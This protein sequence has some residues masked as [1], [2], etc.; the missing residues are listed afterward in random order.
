MKRIRIFLTSI[1]KEIR[2]FLTRVTSFLKGIRIYL[3]PI[4]LLLAA[5]LLRLDSTHDLSWWFDFFQ[6]SKWWLA[7]FILGVA[8]IPITGVIFKF[9]DTKGYIFSKVIGLAVSGYIVWMLG[10]LRI[11]PFTAWVC[12]LVIA[13]CLGINCFV[14]HK[15]KIFRRFIKDKSFLRKIVFQ[16]A[17]FMFALFFWTYLRGMRPEIIGI[18]KFMNF[19]F[20]NSILRSEYFPPPDMWFAGEHIN[21]YYLGHYFSAFLTR[22]SFVPPEISYN[23]MIATL[24]ALSFMGA[25]SIGEFLFE[26]FLQNAKDFQPFKYT[27]PICGLLTGALVALSGNMHTPYYTLFDR[28][29]YGFDYFPP[30]AT[31]YIGSHPYIHGDH[32]IHEFPVYS[33]VLA[34][35][36]AH[37]TN[38]IFVLTAIAV[39]IAVTMSMLEKDKFKKNKYKNNKFKKGG[40]KNESAI[41]II[42]GICLIAL[43][44][45]LFPVAG[46]WQLPNQLIAAIVFA[47]VGV[48]L[49]ITLVGFPQGFKRYWP[50]YCLVVFLIGLFPTTNYWDF[51]IYIVV[52]GV[53]YFYACLRISGYK[54]KALILLIY[55]VLVIGIGAFLV[56]TLFHLNF[57]TISTQVLPV[58]R[59]SAL[60]QLLILY[61][62]QVVFFAMLVVTSILAYNRLKGAQDV[63]HNSSLDMPL[64]LSSVDDAKQPILFDFIEKS[65]PADVI[66]MILFT[67]A[68]GLIIIPEVVFVQDIY[69]NAPRANTMFKLT[70]QAFVMMALGIGYTFTRM[71][72][73]KGEKETF[74]RRALE[75]SVVLLIGA[76]MYPFQMIT[77]EYRHVHFSQYQ[78][79]DGIRHMLVHQEQL[80]RLENEQFPEGEEPIGEPYEWPLVH[81]LFGDYFIVRYINENIEGHPV[82]AEA[83]FFSYTSFGR[84][85]AK[86]GLPSVFNWYTHQH[87]WRSPEVSLTGEYHP[88]LTERIS[89]LATLYT[90]NDPRLAW[91]IIEKYDIRYIV[92]GPLERARY[93]GTI[94]EEMLRSLG[95]IAIETYN[96][97]LIRVHH[98]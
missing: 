46:L 89:D 32:T 70:Y 93:R 6:Y 23:L 51:P 18:E 85:A 80:T 4:V 65:N 26:I 50:G 74:M 59:G 1:A 3:I 94:N 91:G 58:P 95:E 33:F 49:G 2:I 41:E 11:L 44:I 52:A 90:A 84:I 21:Y 48:A 24:F 38:L 66:V 43:L 7:L 27:K 67:C 55:H 5:L 37:V 36:H 68:V 87:L 17:I 82:I 9:F 81:S 16:E 73:C 64:Y 79:L 71:F 62:Y 78:G 57:D 34:D 69:P 30:T 60:N 98:D 86:T 76:F 96:A 20:L 25:Y 54:L 14:N 39:I 13:V 47:V 88:L 42:P 28:E 22:I 10:S 40:S 45:A 61:G 29:S 15:T 53:M 19:G 8:F 12:F 83:D 35:L 77:F 31:R 92:V 75:L 97:Y 63:T 72:L 56:G